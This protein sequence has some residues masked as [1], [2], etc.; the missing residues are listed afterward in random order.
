MTWQEFVFRMNG[1]PLSRAKADLEKVRSLP[2]NEFPHYQ[3]EA[4]MAIAKHHYSNNSFYRK[5]VGDRFPGTLGGFAYHGENRLPGAASLNDFER[6]FGEECVY[7]K[8]FRIL[9]SS[10]VFCPR[11]V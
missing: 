2:E 3:Q 11:Q 8:N 1:Y 5:K 10:H 4:A 6:I 7:L 9:W